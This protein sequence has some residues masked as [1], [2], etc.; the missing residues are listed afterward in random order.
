MP[1]SSKKKSAKK[2]AWYKRIVASVKKRQADFLSRRPHRSFRLTRRRDY[3]RSLVLP[4][5]IA[6]TH[7]VNKTLWQH[8][9]I[10]IWL[11]IVY[12]VLT[13]GLIGL[14]SQDTYSALTETLQESGS[15]I[16][17][18]DWSQAGQAGLLL[19]TI[20]TTGISNTPS[21]AQQIYA[22]LLVLMVWLA[23]VWLLRNLL[24]GHKVKLRDGLY[25]AGAPLVATFLVGL[26]LV[27]QLLPVALAFIA[28]SAA[29]AS[30]LLAGGIEAM[31]FWVGATLLAALSLYWISA[32]FMAMVI[33]T[34]PG[35]YPMKALRIAGDMV[36]GRRVRL[37][38]RLIWMSFVITI[39]WVVVLLP[40]ILFDGWVKGVIPAIEW[41]PI[42]PIVILLLSTITVIWMTSYVYLLYRKIVDDT[43]P[44]A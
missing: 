4:G 5:F 43:A 42:I 39:T 38:L 27:V 17:G 18:G 34:L 8:K 13:V 22:A 15:D 14:A 40:I 29:V 20:M 31:L 16:F 25:S 30:G 3:R 6:F 21:E 41:L 26:V 2:Q 1:R 7:E 35:M 44:P 23:T 9:K 36:V 28:Y 10:F 24:A 19:L 32:T 12:A 37:L 33:V 11:A